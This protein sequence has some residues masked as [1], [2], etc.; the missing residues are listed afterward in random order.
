VEFRE[1]ARRFRVVEQVARGGMGRIEAAFDPLIGRQ[2]A[3][4]TLHSEIREDERAVAKFIEEAR[5]TGQL[6]HPNVV[7]I[8]DLGE[9]DAEPF[10]VMRLVQGKSLA[11]VLAQSSKPATGTESVDL[12]QR[13][14]QIVLRVCDALS[15]A[16]SRGVYH[17]DVKPDNIM[18]G[19]HGQVYLMDWGVAVTDQPREGFGG[20]VAYMAPEQLLGNA[21]AVDARTDVFGLGGVLFEIITG[22]A[23][24]DGKAVL[25]AA[26]WD[27][28]RN[29]VPRDLWQRLPPELCRIA[30][31]A[32]ARE[33]QARYQTVAAF[34]D[35]LEQF[36]K[37]GGWFETLTAKAG[38]TIV[39]EGEPGSTAYIIQSG[40]CDVW[41]LFQGQP[42][43]VRRLGPGDV[44]G[45]TAVFAGGLR[46]ASIVAVDDVTLRVITGDSLNRELD[47]SPILAAFV[48][49]LAG[50]FREADAALSGR[51]GA[52]IPAPPDPK[53]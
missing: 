37:G 26:R 4:K 45:E 44:F 46:T 6:E 51:G 3:I 9:G 39:H 17:C 27:G 14:V 42:R 13:F 25:A 38:E 22:A 41:K 31:K 48:R 19:E 34:R 7:P 33:P 28:A 5:V 30:S 24:N 15:F 32:L 52:S 35:E 1:F 36:L 53:P 23:P 43:L 20:T 2:V 11:Q 40:A 47:Q 50:L 16:H 18:V 49:S 21:D 8:Y 29:F 10:F 12:L